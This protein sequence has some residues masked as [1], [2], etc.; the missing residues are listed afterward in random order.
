MLPETRALV[1]FHILLWAAIT[2]NIISGSIGVFEHFSGSIVTGWRYLAAWLLSFY[3]AVVVAYRE[4]VRR[5]SI[6]AVQANAAMDSLRADAKG[7]ATLLQIRDTQLTQLLL[8]VGQLSREAER[9]H[10]T[11]IT[12]GDSAPELAVEILQILVTR[13]KSVLAEQGLSRTQIHTIRKVYFTVV[14][15]IIN[16]GGICSIVNCSLTMD[17]T[18]EPFFPR[19]LL[20]EPEIWYVEPL[21]PA[22]DRI[23]AM[24]LNERLPSK[25]AI[26]RHQVFVVD[27]EQ[28]LDVR[29]NENG[30]LP[31]GD[32]IE[33]GAIFTLSITDSTGKSWQSNQWFV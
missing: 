26:T 27:Q 4:N 29:P 10:L 15:R 22:K 25:E 3:V 1:R 12:L 8:Q 21:T 23:A 28:T 19:N 13:P 5:A 6:Q 31:D 20:E 24:T 18:R 33:I 17:N 32:P 9:A 7:L 2:G 14:V 16:S 11:A 30:P